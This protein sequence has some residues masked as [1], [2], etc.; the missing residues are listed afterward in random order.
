MSRPSSSLVRS[1]CVFCGSSSGTDP[2]YVETARTFGTLLADRGITL[3]FGG[4]DIGMMGALSRSC[5]EKGGSVLGVITEQLIA[6]EKPAMNGY[7]LVVMKSM[8]ERKNYM[9]EASDAFCILPGGYG[10]LDEA[11]EAITWR[12]LTLHDKPIVI[13]NTNGYWNPLITLLESVIA[14]KFASPETRRLYSVAP[15]AESA[16]DMIDRELTNPIPPSVRANT[17]AF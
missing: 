7:E 6:I 12:Q 8:H 10:T 4:G 15:D 13:V 3:V 2:E 11:F 1:L 14:E 16:L 5:R 9:Y 17:F